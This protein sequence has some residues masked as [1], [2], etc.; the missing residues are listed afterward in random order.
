VLTSSL[1]KNVFKSV[2]KSFKKP[3]EAS[4]LYLYTYIL[5]SVCQKIVDQVFRYSVYY[6]T[7]LCSIYIKTYQ[8]MML[9]IEFLTP[10]V[11]WSKMHMVVPGITK[12]GYLLLMSTIHVVDT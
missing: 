4:Y 12:L 7:L 6:E 3:Y 2:V 8:V 10:G 5:G 1:R 11:I 9:V